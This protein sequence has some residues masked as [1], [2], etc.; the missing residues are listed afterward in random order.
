MKV[1]HT[2]VV[3]YYKLYK[4]DDCRILTRE[5]TGLKKLSTIISK[6]EKWSGMKILVQLT[7]VISSLLHLKRIHN[8]GH[9]NL[10]PEYIELDDRGNWKLSEYGINCK[11]N[12]DGSPSLIC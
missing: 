4:L 9:G 12:K 8:I 2:G 7:N 6:H 5:S 1:R 3:H 11:I 10:S